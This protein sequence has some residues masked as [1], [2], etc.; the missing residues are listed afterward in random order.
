[1]LK[2][3]I[4]FLVVRLNLRANI[5][6]ILWKILHYFH[7]K[8]PK[9]NIPEHIFY[10]ICHIYDVGSLLQNCIFKV[11]ACS[12]YFCGHTF[13]HFGALHQI[14][15]ILRVRLHHQAGLYWY[16][17]GAKKCNHTAKENNKGMESREKY[18][19]RTKCQED[20]WRSI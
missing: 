11:A 13:I 2:N 5:I 1:M 18:Q 19:N 7:Y 6:E 9:S 20:G 4:L 8:V 12:C 3:I 14:H 15:S 16:W 17:K 10:F